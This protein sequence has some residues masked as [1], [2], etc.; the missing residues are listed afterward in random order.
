MATNAATVEQ[1]DIFEVE[2]AGPNDGNPFLEVN[3]TADFRQGERLFTPDGF[4]DGDG[5]YRVR[6]MP[7]APGEWTF[8]T[9]SNRPE[10]DGQTGSF[11]CTAPAPGNHGPVH[12]RNTWYL[13]YAD[14]TPYHQIGTTCYAWTHQPQELQLQTLDTLAQSPFNKLRMCVFPK[15]YRYNKNEPE[16]YPYEGAPLTDWD[17]TRFNPAFWR[18]FEGR[19]TELRELGIEADII[20]FHPYDRWGYASMNAAEDDRYLRYAVA[21][22][23]SC[24]NVW[25]SMANEFDL[26][27]DKI[28]A[29]WDRF[30]QV[31]QQ[32]DP[33]NHLRGIHNCR[34]WY[35]HTRPWVTHASIQSHSFD[36]IRQWREKCRKPI[37]IDEC[38][39]EGNLPH[40]WGDLTSEEMARY[41]WLGT[42]AGAYVGHGETYQHPE[43]IIW[44]S[45]G[46]VLRGESPAR[47]AFLKD[48]MSEA[49]PFEA[50]TPEPGPADGVLALALPGS[51]YLYHFTDA[52][53]IEITLPGDQAYRVDRVDA[54]EMT[55]ERM[56]GVVSG[57]VRLEAPKG[58]YLLRLTVD[59]SG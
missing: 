4:Y 21:R 19:V 8:H 46:G 50:L 51:Q 41:F 53:E 22:L 3:L 16:L 54:W 40:H 28:E 14:G 25:W 10:L 37:L 2:L 30:F 33:Y 49:P 27:E 35:D 13:A 20:L 55:V 45:K 1:W 32:A 17:F 9:F 44:W 18:H 52:G 43:D 31:V 39:Y 58:D 42:M 7:D 24:R 12:V 36:E 59:A 38:R 56:P 34:E 23:A 15:S 6:F 47:I 5:V 48:I 26:M 57:G 11:T 29:D